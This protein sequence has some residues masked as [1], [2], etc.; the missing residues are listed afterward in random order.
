MKADN[1]KLVTRAYLL[2]AAAL[3]TSILLG[4]GCVWGFVLTSKREVSRIEVRSAE[5]DAAFERQVSLAYK[6]DSLYNNMMLLSTDRRINGLV[7]QN[8]I[9][10]QKIDMAGTLESMNKAD[11][12]LYGRM[13]ERLNDI[14]Q[15]KDSIR[16][17]D[18]QVEQTK[19]DLQRCIEN[20]RAATR[21]MITR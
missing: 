9:S 16:L 19:G 17:I 8:R 4:V 7:M 12:L 15:V 2:F 18:M 13:S 10:T 20:N 5:Y 21:R 14:L 3:G 1:G 6:V 11:A